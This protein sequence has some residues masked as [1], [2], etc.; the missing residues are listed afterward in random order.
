MDWSC[1]LFLCGV[2]WCCRLV[3]GLILLGCHLAFALA[4]VG[5]SG[6]LCFVFDLI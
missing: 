3:D 4:G 5:F 2:S 6:L 1:S